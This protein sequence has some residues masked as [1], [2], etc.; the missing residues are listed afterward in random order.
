MKRDMKGYN[1]GRGMVKENGCHQGKGKENKKKKAVT[2]KE[3]RMPKTR[4]GGKKPKQTA[5][6]YV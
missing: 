5:I 2:K 4:A 6:A 3:E 1:H